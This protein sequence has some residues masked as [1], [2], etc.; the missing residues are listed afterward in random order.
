VRINLAPLSDDGLTVLSTKD[1]PEKEWEKRGIVVPAP[2]YYLGEYNTS[3]LNVRDSE[4]GLFEIRKERVCKNVKETA[5]LQISSDGINEEYNDEQIILYIDDKIKKTTSTEMIDLIYFAKYQPAAGFKFAVDGFHNI[6]DKKPYIA[7]YCL[8]PPAALYQDNLD[9]NAIHLNS[10]IDWDSALPSPRFVEGF[11]NFPNIKFDKNLT[12]IID[13]RSVKFTRTRAVFE[14]IGWAI[15][16]IFSADG[17][18]QSGI[19]Q[20][21]VIN[22]AVPKDIINELPM[23]DPWPYLND[24]ISSKK[25]KYLEYMSVLVRLLDGQREV[26][27]HL[28]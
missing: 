9:A 15:C 6:N 4:K 27:V 2:P 19:Y 13:V 21:P 10:K 25:L 1:F 8:N 20:I 5:L 16:P 3:L 28:R 24:L 7:F 23:N 17:Y 14:N 11:V 26:R 18:V 12:M 22:G